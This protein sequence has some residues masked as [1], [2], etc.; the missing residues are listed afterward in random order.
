MDIGQA[1]SPKFKMELPLMPIKLVSALSAKFLTKRPLLYGDN[2]IEP[3]T[4]SL[5]VGPVV[6]MPTL[7]LFA[8]LITSVC[9]PPAVVGVKLK[10][11]GPEDCHVPNKSATPSLMRT[12]NV[13]PR[14]EESRNCAGNTKA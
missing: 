6:P 10:S 11:V 13:V 4:W 12:A 2:L 1:A 5:C 7:P 3:A 14:E 9:V 8:I